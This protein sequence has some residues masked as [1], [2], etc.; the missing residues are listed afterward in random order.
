MKK[1][2]LILTG[3]SGIFLFSCSGGENQPEL[4]P[5][6]SLVRKIDTI[7]MRITELKASNKLDKKLASAALEAYTQFAATYKTDSLTPWYLYKAADIA[8][9]ALGDHKKAVDLYDIILAGHKKFPKYPDCLFL[10]GFISQ[11]KLQ[12]GIKAK[13][14]YD[15]LIRDFPDHDFVD[16]AQA[17]ISF[18]GKTD[19]E[20]IREFEKKNQEMQKK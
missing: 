6:D 1:L 5:R 13:E 3:I 14:Y 15:E 11:D 8:S 16:D 2:L 12:N 10:A 17:M 19:E 20:I 9:A 18:F 4:S 7:E